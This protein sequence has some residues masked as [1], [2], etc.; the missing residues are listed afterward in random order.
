MKVITNPDSNSETNIVTEYVSQTRPLFGQA[1]HVANFSFLFKDNNHGWDGQLAFAYTGDRLCI[2]SRYVDEDS[3]QAGYTSLDASIEKRFKNG[4]TIIVKASNLLNSPMI[5]YIK[6]N[7][8]NKLYTNV[9]RYNEGIVE[10]KEYYGQ[11]FLIGLRF[12]IK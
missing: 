7:D 5:Q 1:A 11:N 9:E 8:I 6:I 3:W 4:V 10:R 2:V 12:T